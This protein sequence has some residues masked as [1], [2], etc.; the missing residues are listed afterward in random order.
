MNLCAA[1]DQE[2]GASV[3]SPESDEI[4]GKETL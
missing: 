3:T 1:D 2:Q 4:S